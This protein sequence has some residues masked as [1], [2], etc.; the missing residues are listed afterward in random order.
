MKLINKSTGKTVEIFNDT[1][2]PNTLAELCRDWE[3]A[4]KPEPFNEVAEVAYVA[5]Y[6]SDDKIRDIKIAD[7]DYYEILPDGTKKTEFTWDEAMEIEEKTNGKWRLPTEQ[8]WFIIAGTFGENENGE[9]T[10]EALKENLNLEADGDGRGYYWSSTPY[11]ATYAHYLYFSSMLVNPQN[12]NN[13]TNGF[14]VRCV[15]R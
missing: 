7:Q 13:K 2:L 15:A 12:G 10:G 1:C 4:P 14:T 8:E 3:D 11:A 5:N 6:R 9:I